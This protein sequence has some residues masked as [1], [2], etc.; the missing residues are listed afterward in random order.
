VKTPNSWPAAAAASSPGRA[1]R[2]HASAAWAT[3]R[4]VHS[5]AGSGREGRELGEA[6]DEAEQVAGQRVEGL[7]GSVASV[8]P[9]G[10]VGGAYLDE[11]SDHAAQ[12]RQ[13]RPRIGQH[14]AH[15]LV[16]GRDA[17]L[18]DRRA[19]ASALEKWRY[20]VERLTPAVAASRRMSTIGPVAS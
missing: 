18:G 19:I 11:G 14:A 9:G 5:D 4:R 16:R 20:S 10:C 17:P 2:R 7:P 6:V 8:A 3:A 1:A 15:R 13:R 12:L